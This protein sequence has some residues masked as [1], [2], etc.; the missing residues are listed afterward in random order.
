MIDLLAISH[1]CSLAVN[2]AIYRELL[3]TGWKLEL[4]IPKRLK[5]G[6][7]S[8][9]AE[10][11]SPGDP[12]LHF[13]NLIASHPRFFTY[14]GLTTTL[15][16]LRPKIILLENSPASF[17]TAQLGY[18]TRW[19]HSKLI[20]LSCDNL[21]PNPLQELTRGRLKVS[22]SGF[23]NYI[24]SNLSRPHI[25]HIFVLSSDGIRVMKGLGHT[26]VSQIP[27]G[28]DPSLFFPNE[29]LRKETRRRL[30]LTETTV[31]YIGRLT[32]Q[33]GVHILI[34]GLAQIKDLPWQLLLDRFNTYQNPYGERLQ[35]LIAEKELTSRVVYFDA[36]HEEIP[37]FMNA[38]DIV[39]APSI[40]MPNWKEQY[41]RVVPEAMACGKL[42]I[43]S[44][45]GALPELVGDA[46]LIFPEGN[47]EKL[48]E[49]LRKAMMSQE[50]RQK[51]GTLAEQ[52]ATSRFSITTQRE[53]MNQV[54][55][56]FSNS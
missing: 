38:A 25:D 31:S 6:K 22:L 13:L 3:R 5:I 35:K 45:C 48:A 36:K 39:V 42:V 16:Q 53:L 1:A 51:I 12:P 26:H 56:K 32:Y 43:A 29:K 34:E 40:S 27:L 18:W 17:L 28:Y 21:L 8:H 24:L 15:D 7:I 54:L 11:Q 19:R 14:A 20:C 41:G 55:S 37:A 9:E 44:D 33:K 52:R 50:M 10:L 46:G 23:A 49:I 47:S 4:I 2:R 30:G